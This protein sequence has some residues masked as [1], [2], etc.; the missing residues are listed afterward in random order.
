MIGRVALWGDVVE[1]PSGW[2]ASHAYPI[3]LVRSDAG[4]R[5]ERASP[6]RLLDE[7]LVALEA[8]EVP[9]DL[10]APSD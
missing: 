4:G 5:A 9:V 7:I 10:V 6:A 2:R 3:E 8:Y 1:G